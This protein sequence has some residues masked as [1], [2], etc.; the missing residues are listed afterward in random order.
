MWP[1]LQ[2]RRALAPTTAVQPLRRPPTAEDGYGGCGFS[3]KVPG[4]RCSNR[5]RRADVPVS[6]QQGLHRV[7]RLGQKRPQDAEAREHLWPRFVPPGCGFPTHAAPTNAAGFS[8]VTRP[9]PPRLRPLRAPSVSRLRIGPRREP[10]PHVVSGAAVRTF[11]AGSGLRVRQSLPMARPG[12]KPCA[13]GPLNGRPAAPR[14]LGPPPREGGAAQ[15]MSLALAGDA[16]A[17]CGRVV[18]VGSRSP[19]GSLME[20]PSL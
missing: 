8:G 7:L 20:A 16:V 1:E 14:L 2:S 15:R 5:P 9:A 13:A 19:A 11:L 10:G 17:R 6:R 12:E 3:H 18:A 4:N